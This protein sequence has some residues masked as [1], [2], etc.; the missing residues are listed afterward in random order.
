MVRR[1]ETG[2]SSSVSRCSSPAGAS[3]V[4]VSAGAPGSRPQA[5]VERLVAEAGCQEPPRREPVRRP[6]R[7]VKP[8][9]SSDLQPESRAGHVAAKA[10][11]A[12]PESGGARVAG[13]GGVRGAARVHGEE[14]NTR[15][16][17]AQPKSGPRA[18]YKPPAK[19]SV[20]Q[21]ESEGTVVVTSR[22]TNHAR[23]AKGPCGG[24]VGHASTH[25]GLTAR[26][27]HPGGRESA[28]EVRQFQRRLW[29]AAKQ[30]PGRRF[31]ALYD[32]IYRADILWDAWRRVKRNR[33]AA[34]ID[35]RLPSA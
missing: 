7:E 25:E 35:A 26:S 31:H 15:G 1:D 2:R 30:Q 29:K 22:A 9:A 17:S 33:G 11:S 28:D 8:A 16:P 10:M 18:S 3:P 34:G 19:A 24:N 20:A 27:N 13:L 5:S 6:Q 21:R 14:R 4:S 12:A 32:R 23:G